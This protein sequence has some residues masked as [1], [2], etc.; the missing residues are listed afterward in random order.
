VATAVIKF[1]VKEE[2]STLD[3][4]ALLQRAYRDACVGASNVKIMG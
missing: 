3:N 2:I 4:N 1:L